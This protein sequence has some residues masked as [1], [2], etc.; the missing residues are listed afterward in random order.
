MPPISEAEKQ[1]R[2]RVIASSEGSLAME[3]QTLDAVTQ[4]LSQRYVEGELTLKQFGEEV[5]QHVTLLVERM[6]Q[7]C[8]VVPAA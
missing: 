5:E 7:E 3:G 6:K 4:E 2:R 1:H 8:P